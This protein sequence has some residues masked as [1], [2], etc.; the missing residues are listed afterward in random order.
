MI[1]IVVAVDAVVGVVVCVVYGFVVSRVSI[2]FYG[3]KFA[4]AVD[5]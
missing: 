3:F 2:F 5:F 1:V 4:S